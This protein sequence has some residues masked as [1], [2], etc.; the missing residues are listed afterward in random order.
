ML[1]CAYTRIEDGGV[2]IIH[3]APDF[4]NSLG[5]SEEDG[6]KLLCDKDVPTGTYYKILNIDDLPP[7]E[8]RSAWELN[9]DES[10]SDGIGLTKEQFESKYPQYKGWAVQ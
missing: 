7:R 10:N 8:F 3:P 2:S 9:L 6:I 5:V 1:V 4:I